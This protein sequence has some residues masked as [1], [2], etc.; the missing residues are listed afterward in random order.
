MFKN[1]IKLIIND[2]DGILKPLLIPSESSNGTGLLNPSIF[3]EDNIIH[4]IIRNVEYTLYHAE[5]RQE[6]QSVFEGPLS[7]YHRDD[8]LELKTNNFYCN[9]DNKTLEIIKSMRIDTSKLDKKPIWNFIGL[10]DARLVK[11]NNKYYLCG[12]RRDTTTNGQGRMELSEIEITDDK[13]IEINRYRIEVP[14]KNSYCEKNWMPI[15]DKPFHFVKWSNPTEIVKVSLEECKSTT[16]YKAENIYQHKQNLS[17][18]RGGSPLINWNND[19]YLCIVHEVDFIP[20]NCNGFKDADYYHR[21]I[22]FNKDFSINFIS[23]KFNFMTAKIEFCIGLSQIN[24]DILIAFG[25][26]DNCSYLVKINKI[27]LENLLNNELNKE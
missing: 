16:I 2:Y 22:I 17:N 25:F 15:I 20:K 11:W 27:N 1:L 12:V 7:Y 24:N 26:Q 23:D 6:Y 10:E 4:C 13:V 3:V 18:L 19:Q 9:I 21:F 8:K 5:G 14:D